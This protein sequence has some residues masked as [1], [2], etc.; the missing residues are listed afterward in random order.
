MKKYCSLFLLI[1]LLTHAFA[2]QTADIKN[3]MEYC[4]TNFRF[5]GVVLLADSNKVIYEH[6][7]GKANLQTNE[8]LEPG[9]KFRLGSMSKQF[10]SFIML[11]LIDKGRLS[12]NDHLAKFIGAFDQP[13]KQNITIRNLLTHTSGLAD[14]TNLKNF[15]DKIY[16]NEDSI[17]K[18]IASSEL[19]FPPSSSYGYSN[20]NFY[21]LALIIEKITGKDFGD[22]LNEMVLK[23]AGMSNSGE[24]NGNAIKDEAKGYLFVHDS[25]L[26]APYIEMKNT[27]GGGGMYSTAED[28]LKWSL[29]FQHRLAA[30]TFLKNAIQPFLL[31]GGTKTVYAC[32]W[33]LIPGIIFHEGHINGFANLIAIDTVHHQTIILLTNDDYHQLYITMESLK[34]ILQGK[35][36]YNNWMTNNPTTNNLADYRGAYTIGNLRVNLKDTSNLLEGDAFGQVQFLRWFGNDE[37]FFLDQEGIIKFERDNKGN[38]IGLKSFDNYSWVEL[39]KE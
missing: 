31:P 24:E 37:F 32:G 28:L 1:V 8:N 26:A 6:A 34:N 16:Y 29:F 3:F 27:K 13:D 39:K 7:F 20:S 11:Q 2:Q 23:K 30:D 15:N 38:V 21:L 4:Q 18:M 22:V 19:S 5:N 25:T 17:V 35:A 33:C 36:K 14:Y 10:T 12:F 9:T